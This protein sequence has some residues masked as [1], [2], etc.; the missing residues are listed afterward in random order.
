[1]TA[2]SHRL[3]AAAAIIVGLI[4]VGEV[5]WRTRPPADPMPQAT[6]TAAGRVVSF[7]AARTP[8]GVIVRL[9]YTFELDGRLVKAKPQTATPAEEDAPAAERFADGSTV[10]VSYDPGDPARSLVREFPGT[11]PLTRR[12][13]F[14]IGAVILVLGVAY[15]VIHRRRTDE[16]VTL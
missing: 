9:E 16:K 12:P 4:L 7:T 15:A 11:P 2:S 14:L 13:Q 5:A 10:T 8:D 1:M 3:P 6:A